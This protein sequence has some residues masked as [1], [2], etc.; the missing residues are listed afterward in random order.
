MKA[1]IYF[2]IGLAATVFFTACTKTN[3]QGRLIP[4]NAAV[5]IEADGKS[6]LSKVSWEEIKQNQIFQAVY[7]DSS[8]KETI[9]KLLD[10][11]EKAGIDI[12][13]DL[14]LFLQ[15]DSIGGYMGIE[16]TVKD[17]AALKSFNAELTGGGS[18]TENDGVHFISRSPVCAAWNNEKFLYL[19]DLPSMKKMD[20]LS[21]R[22]MTDSIDISSDTKA[23]D[24]LASA[25]EVFALK[26]GN[27]LA[28]NERFTTLMKQTG[29]IRFWI[30]TEE[31]SKSTGSFSPMM[32]INLDK[33]S[34]GNV[35]TFA[36]TF[37]N[38]KILLNGHSYAGE[39][40]T[41]LYKKYGGG[42]V[43]EDMLKRVPGKDIVMLAGF[44]FKPEGLKEFLQLL[45]LDGLLN[46][47]LA[48]VGFTV[49][50]FI[51]ANKGDVIFGVSDLQ[52]NQDT[53]Q[54]YLFKDDSLDAPSRIKPTFNF[55]FA[56]SIGDKDAFN[57]LVNAGK[58]IGGNFSNQS[59][60][61]VAYSSNGNYF[62]LSNSKE[63]ADK[64]LA[65]AGSNGDLVNKI[66]GDAFAGYVNL[67]SIFKVVPVN[68]IKDST[69]KVAFDLSAKLWDNILW[70]GGNFEDGGLTQKL[71]INLMDK[72]T[73][74]LKQLNQY[75]NKLGE[76]YNEKRKK[77]KEDIMAFEDA[78]TPATAKD[79]VT[80]PPSTAGQKK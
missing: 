51:K 11:P 47:G 53:A 37:D 24:I 36:A 12:N 22:M 20:E 43:S 4:A 61:P 75:S 63:N 62:V 68:E 25:K 30:N 71:E 21:K 64:Y 40:L 48:T 31:L 70:K 14:L 73:N 27:S 42:K 77:E 8:T 44:N 67:Q 2:L 34:K 60:M 28:K 7:E 50:D 1:R 19:V 66:S 59:E 41:K 18:E 3:T 49:D 10:N 54:K 5:V 76:L 65:G 23:R 45:G 74:S 39:E 15:K 6:L 32:P 9:K 55:A 79:A 72:T 16:G 58:K 52:L 78:V 35:T 17:A 26:E 46:V 13:N 29:D 38:G 57:K 56:T 80:S 33:I 69:G